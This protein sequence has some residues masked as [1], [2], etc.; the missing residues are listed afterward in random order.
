MKIT[1]LKESRN[2]K[3]VK[4]ALPALVAAAPAIA[5][6][7]GS[8]MDD[9]SEETAEEIIGQSEARPLRV[10]AH[11]DEFR[12]IKRI[13]QAIQAQLIK[14]SGA[15]DDKDTEAAGN[16]PAQAIDEGLKKPVRRIYLKK[17]KTL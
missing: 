2:K 5:K 4:E 7:I 13:L 6:A 17:L 1:I 10:Q 9:E 14:M 12:S 8:V 16:M 11:G 15:V 3:V